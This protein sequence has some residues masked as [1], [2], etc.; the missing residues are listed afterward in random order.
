MKKALRIFGC[1][2]LLI[3]TE[4]IAKVWKTWY[5]PYKVSLC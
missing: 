5:A 2:G 4:T 1:E 3:F